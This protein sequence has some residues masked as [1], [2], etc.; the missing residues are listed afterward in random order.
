MVAIADAGC[1]ALGHAIMKKLC[2]HLDYNVK[3]G[4]S[5]TDVCIE[6]IRKQKDCTIEETLELLSLKLAL[7]Y[8]PPPLARSFWK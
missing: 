3:P 7:D 1:G 8:E 5:F 6:Y 2:I 4:M